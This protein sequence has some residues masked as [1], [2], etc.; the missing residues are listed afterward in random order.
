[1]RYVLREGMKTLASAPLEV[2]A[3]ELS[4]TA[5]EQATTGASFKVSWSDTVASHDYYTVVS[6]GTDEGKLGNR[7]LVGNKGEGTLR[8]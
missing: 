4:I 2:V 5:P 1:V 7:D 3:A 6:V 8:A